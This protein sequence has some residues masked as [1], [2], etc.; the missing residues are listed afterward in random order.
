MNCPNK[1]KPDICTYKEMYDT[2]TENMINNNLKKMV[3]IPTATT[4]YVIYFS[5]TYQV[6]FMKPKHYQD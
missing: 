1:P 4:I 5:L 2:F 3:R 6:K